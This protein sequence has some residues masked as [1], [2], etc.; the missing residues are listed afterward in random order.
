MLSAR[1]DGS[2]APPSNDSWISGGNGSSKSSPMT[3][4]PA[5]NPPR[6]T[7]RSPR[8]GT[9]RTTGTP[10]REMTTSFPSSARTSGFES[11]VF[12]SPTGTITAP[13]SARLANGPAG[14]APPA[15]TAGRDPEAET[16]FRPAQPW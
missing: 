3:I 8:T 15:V 10:D 13:G 16:V 5:R 7:A 12:A 11:V 9:R 6:R 2:V 1:G 14:E 4:C